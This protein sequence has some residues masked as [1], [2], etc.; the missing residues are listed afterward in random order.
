[1]FVLFD[2]KGERCSSGVV[3]KTQPIQLLNLGKLLNRAVG[4]KMTWKGHQCDSSSE[5]SIFYFFYFLFFI[6]PICPLTHN[7]KIKIKLV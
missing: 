1:M 5:R 7:F 2:C 3:S 6:L 4:V